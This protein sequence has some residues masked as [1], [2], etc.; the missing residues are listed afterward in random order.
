[1]ALTDESLVRV[2]EVQMRILHDYERDFS[3]YADKFTTPKIIEIFNIIPAVLAKENKKFMFGMIKESARAREYEGALLWLIRAG[4]ASRVNRVTR[5]VLPLKAY[6]DLGAFKLFTLD[7]GL[8]GCQ[9]GVAPEKILVQ[10]DLREFKGAL[11]EQ[12]VAQE[13][14][15]HRKDND[16][17]GAIFYYSADDSRAEIDFVLDTGTDLIPIEVKSGKNLGSASLNSLLEAN[18]KM[19]AVKFSTLPYKDNGQIINMPIYGVGAVRT[20][21][22]QKWCE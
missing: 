15:A 11:A 17:S 14:V 2:R 19:R 22:A 4:V 8:L 13:L 6:M 16:Y 12:F 5:V 10:D 20:Y 21:F 3:Q 9:A 7:I 1:T 18:P